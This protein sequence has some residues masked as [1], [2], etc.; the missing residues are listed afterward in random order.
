LNQ[1]LHARGPIDR[2][3]NVFVGIL[4]QLSVVAL[5]QQLGVG[6]HHAQRLLQIMR[7]H[8]GKLL[9]IAIGAGE[10]FERSAMFLA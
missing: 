7:G 8:V 6:R 1:A 5:G 3:M 4:V 10:F 9:Q 2:V